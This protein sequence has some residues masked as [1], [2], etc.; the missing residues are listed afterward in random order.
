MTCVV[1]PAPWGCGQFAPAPMAAQFNIR[2]MMPSRGCF[3][4]EER[5]GRSFPVPPARARSRCSLHASRCALVAA[6]LP[7]PP[8]E[9]RDRERRSYSTSAPNLLLPQPVGMPP[10]IGSFD[11]GGLLSPALSSKGGEGGEP[12]AR[13]STP[14]NAYEVQ[15]PRAQQAPT[16]P[17]YWKI[18]GT[19]CWRTLLRP[20]R[21]HSYLKAP[22]QGFVGAL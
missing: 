10:E 15:H 2:R 12:P 11:N 9:E 8:L 5:F 3:S 13:C 17:A 6:L 20:G 22:S 7:S 16:C 18:P 19:H 14:P 1:V 21:A 4:S